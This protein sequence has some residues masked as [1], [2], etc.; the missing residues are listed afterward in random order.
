MM[1]RVN[2]LYALV[3]SILLI[4]GTTSLCVAEDAPLKSG[5]DRSNFDASVSPAQ[6]FF[7]YVNGNWIKN[8]PIPPDQS[9]WGSFSELHE[10]DLQ[11]LKQI[12]EQLESSSASSGLD[13]DQRKLRDFYATA[14][15]EAKLQR[16]GA[17]PLKS[18]FDKIVAISN[19][20]DLARTIAQLHRIGAAPVFSFRIGQ[21]EKNST[22]YIVSLS[23]G[24]LSLPERNY[25]VG[26]DA[27][28]KAFR[29]KFHDHVVKMLRFSGPCRCRAGRHTSA[30]ICSTTPPPT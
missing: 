3:S 26:T 21:D 14:M 1:N 20:D 30:G 9:R 11:E 23:Q 5:I 17:A 24:G 13:E 19:G 16:E 27:D 29:A 22:Q 8:N 2:Q 4:A 28:S 18:E 6:D 10:R 7:E 15:D 12:F 25:Y